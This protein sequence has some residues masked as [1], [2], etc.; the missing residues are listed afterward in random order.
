MMIETALQDFFYT[1]VT[2]VL[3]STVPV[4]WYHPNAERPTVPY[5]A[6]HISSDTRIGGASMRS[7]PDPITG[8][9]TISEKRELGLYC[10]AHGL[11]SRDFLSTMLKSLS[12][13]SIIQ[14]FATAG[15][16]HVRSEGIHDISVVRESTWEERKSLYLLQS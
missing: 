2:A 8:I 14:T 4:I 11:G 6:L 10:Q 13:P 5:V 9:V 15:I 12:R 16:A 3:G 1:W 7:A